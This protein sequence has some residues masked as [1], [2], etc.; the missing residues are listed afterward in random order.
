MIEYIE[1][2]YIRSY[3]HYYLQL[4]PELNLFY[5]PNGVG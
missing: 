5:G 4:K 3:E 1:L 2:R